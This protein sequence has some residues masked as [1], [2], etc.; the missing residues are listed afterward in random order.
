[1][2][3]R[4]LA[5]VV[6]VVAVGGAAVALLLHRSNARSPVATA[7]LPVAPAD[8][9]V[10]VAAAPA[11]PVAVSPGG[12]DADGRVAV[13]SLEEAQLMARLRELAE[14]EP[15]RAVALA[16]EGNRRFPDSPYA[17]ERTSILIHA[18]AEEGESMKAR[19]EAEEMV[20]HYP[21]SDWV[22]EI[23]RFTGAHRH[24]NLRIT[25]AGAMIYQ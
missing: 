16:R 8:G 21:D 11:R 12:G 18:L 7:E 9:G 17:P 13:A 6:A 4:A 2:S 3:R 20:N 24:R 15:Q 10:R 25:D 1:M 5:S 14:H 22:R 23:E 19:G